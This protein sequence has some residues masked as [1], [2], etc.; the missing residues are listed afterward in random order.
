MYLR[1]QVPLPKDVVYNTTT[2][3]L[4]LCLF[5][6]YPEHPNYFLN[7]NKDKPIKKFN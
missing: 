1:H 5:Y 6:E 2:K 7:L 3:E 4:K